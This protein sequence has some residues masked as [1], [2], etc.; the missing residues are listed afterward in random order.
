MTW[1]PAPLSALVPPL[2]AG[3]LCACIPAVPV[4]T[5]AP[6]GNVRWSRIMIAD[7]RALLSP[8]ERR[9][10]DAVFARDAQPAASETLTVVPSFVF[11]SGAL[12]IDGAPDASVP[13]SR[14][15]RQDA[16][17]ESF[18]FGRRWQ[19]IY[20]ITVIP[21]NGSAPR[22]FRA[23]QVARKSDRAAA[24][25]HTFDAVIRAIA[26]SAAPRP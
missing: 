1:I 13:E 23:T 19:A 10:L 14:E 21:S 2:F 8:T 6:F 18:L 22:T 25:A 16:T 11:R 24:R 15:V 4:L 20:A 26:Q 7:D 3:T 12:G 5:S 9:R 17:T